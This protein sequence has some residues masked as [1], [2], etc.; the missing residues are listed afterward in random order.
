MAYVTLAEAARRCGTT[1]QL[2]RR[3]INRGEIATFTDPV[4]ERLT[5]VRV[6]DLDR[7]RQP[8]PIAPRGRAP[9]PVGA[10]DVVA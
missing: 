8:Q 1:R 3:R 4:D 10:G 7:L 9:G 5:L 2:L 6:G